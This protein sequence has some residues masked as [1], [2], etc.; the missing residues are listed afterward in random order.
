MNRNHPDRAD[1]TQ[2]QVSPLTRAIRRGLVYGSV[3][4]VSS[5]LAAA[6][7]SAIRSA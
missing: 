3:I 1:T 5:T 4:A 6:P 2:L 7:A